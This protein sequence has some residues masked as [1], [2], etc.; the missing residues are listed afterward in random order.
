MS[1]ATLVLTCVA[2][3][4]CLNVELSGAANLADLL[5]RSFVE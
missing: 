5:Q 2:G 4:Y 3:R 1:R